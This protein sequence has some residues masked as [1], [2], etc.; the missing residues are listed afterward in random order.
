MIRGALSSANE[1]ESRHFA[2]MSKYRC[3][4]ADFQQAKDLIKWAFELSEKIQNVVMVRSVTRLSHASE[5][6]SSATCRMSRKMRFSSM[7]AVSWIPLRGPMSSLPVA[8]KHCW[9]QEKLKQAVAEFEASPF[10][11]AHG[12]R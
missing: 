3:E 7:K 12:C 11:E 5:T 8:F 10:N 2:R 6:S 4:P 9:Q 1:G